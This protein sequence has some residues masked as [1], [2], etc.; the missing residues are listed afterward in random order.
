APG[1]TG[2]GPERLPALV[3]A[4][5]NAAERAEDPPVVSVDAGSERD[6]ALV[7]AAVDALGGRALPVGSA[8]LAGELAR[9]WLPAGTA[10]AEAPAVARRGTG[11]VLVLVSSLHQ[12]ARTQVD[13]LREALPAGRFLGLGPDTDQLV[14]GEAAATWGRTALGR[15]RDVPLVALSAPPVADS[16]PVQD[17]PSRVAPALAAL[18]RDLHAAFPFGAVVVTGGDGARAL[19]DALGATGIRVLGAVDE[20]VPHGV[21]VGGPAE[22]LPIVT[23]AGGFG[24]ADTLLRCVEAV[25][26]PGR[27]AAGGSTEDG[28]LDPPREV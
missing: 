14:D 17:M 7:A 1:G 10:P 24:D 15:R 3:R 28:G 16:P 18:A 6:L 13:R 23:K 20:G 19:V 5:V 2:T 25:G 12:A 9:R 11:P 8:G 21:L 4:L 26:A 27:T 22:G